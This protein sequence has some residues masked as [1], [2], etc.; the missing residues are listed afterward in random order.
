[1]R[2]SDWSSDVCSSDLANIHPND[3]VN[4]SQSTNDAYATAVRLATHAANE[5]LGRR[6]VMLSE[7]LTAKASQF[8]HI[9]K[10]GRTQLQDAVPMTLGQEFGAFAAT[11]AEAD[12]KSTRLNSSH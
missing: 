4:R 5:H 12:R 11:I 2:I 1:M 3:H 9:P 8:D 10:L 6:L 7:A